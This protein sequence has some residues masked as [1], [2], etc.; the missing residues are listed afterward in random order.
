MANDFHDIAVLEVMGERGNDSVHPRSTER[1]TEQRVHLEREVERRRPIGKLNDIPLGRKNEDARLAREEFLHAPGCLRRRTALLVSPMRS[2]AILRLM[3]H[4]LR[5][6]LDLDEDIGGH[7]GELGQRRMETAIAIGL[8]E[9]N[10]ILEA[11]RDRMPS[12]MEMAENLVAFFRRTHDHPESEEIVHIRDGR[13][14]LRPHLHKNAVWLLLSD[15]H[16][17]RHSLFL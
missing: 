10:V 17:G 13:H 5:P 3:S 8:G 11:V 1:E 6:H 9:G 7:T 4:L 16:G 15:F 12:T 14:P 2:N